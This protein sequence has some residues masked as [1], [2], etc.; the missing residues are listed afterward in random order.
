ME[1]KSHVSRICGRNNLFSCASVLQLYEPWNGLYTYS[2]QF[3]VCPSNLHIERLIE[4]EN[5]PSVRRQRCWPTLEWTLFIICI[6]RRCGQGGIAQRSLLSCESF[7][8]FGV[9]RHVLFCESDDSGKTR[10]WT[11]KGWNLIVEILQGLLLTFMLLVTAYLVRHY[12]FTLTVLRN[13]G[14]RIKPNSVGVTAYLPTVSVMIP[15]HNEEMVIGRI[16]QRMS[17]LTYP[18]DKTQ[19]VVIDDASMDKTGEIVQRFSETHDHVEVLHRSEHEGG[20]GKASALNAG[21]KLAKGEIVLCFDADYYPQRDIVEQLVKEFSDPLVGAVQGRVIVLNEPHNVVTRLVALERIGGYRIDQ[22][23]RDSLGLITQF[24]GTV[25]GFRKSLLESLGGWDRSILAED[26]D[27]TFRVYLAGF[28]VRYV[29][30]AE[31]YEEAVESW[32][33]YRKQRY[34]WARGHMQCAFKHLVK[35]FKSKHLGFKQ[36]IDALLLL[37]VYFMPVVVLFSWIISVP[38]LFLR[39]PQWLGIAWAVMPLSVYSFVG[40]FAPFFEVEIG[41]YLDGRT[42]AHWLISLLFLTFLYNI[43]ICTKALVDVLVSRITRRNRVRWDKTVHSGDGN[44]YIMN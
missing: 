6:R 40:N 44:S 32:Q 16:L 10:N 20:R 41:A 7:H 28:K 29:N 18:C 25:G 19:I 26:T 42:R 8:E 12:I 14:K 22:Q 33:A 38:L 3:S 34:R 35:V 9:D 30:E 23:A 15:A 1:N 11:R 21:L 27:L 37:N 13:V 5:F 36:K 4:N 31:C 39:P 24:G 43:P 17:E 2:F